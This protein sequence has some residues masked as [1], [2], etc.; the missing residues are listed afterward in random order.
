MANN[1][2][3]L[4]PELWPFVGD[5][6]RHGLAFKYGRFVASADTDRATAAR[7]LLEPGR[8]H[9]V[10]PEPIKVAEVDIAIDALETAHNGWNNFYNEP[11]P[12]RTL[13]SLAGHGGRIP[14]AVMPK[15]VRVVVKAFLGNGYGVADAALPYYERMIGAFDPRQAARALRA[16][17]NPEV[18]SVLRSTSGGR[19]WTALLDLLEPKLTLFG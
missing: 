7:E 6:T 19:Q 9:R 1:V 5:D 13:A 4:W 3:R 17:T 2:R 14:D 10:P 15:Y 11:A 18:Y 12:A 16:F 8:R